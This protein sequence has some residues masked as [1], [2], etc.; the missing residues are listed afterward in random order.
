V[1]LGGDSQVAFQPNQELTDVDCAEAKPRI[2]STT[3][4]CSL[5]P[6]S[7]SYWISRDSKLITYMDWTPTRS[8]LEQTIG[9]LW[10]TMIN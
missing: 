8:P 2:F 6:N 5:K 9:K 7:P 1:I 3:W 4:R 10:K